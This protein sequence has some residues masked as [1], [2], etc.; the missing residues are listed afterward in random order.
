MGQG[1]QQLLAVVQHHLPLE[2]HPDGEGEMAGAGAGQVQH[3]FFFRRPGLQRQD[4]GSRT[5]HRLHKVAH[6]FPGGDIALRQQLAV[7]RLHG[8]LADFQMGSQCPLGG[9]LL[10]R[11][12]SSGKN[13][14]PDTAVQGLIEGHP[15]GFFQFVS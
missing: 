12:Q 6:L 3:R 2:L 5:L 14:T 1:L 13:I 15:R 7:S 11:R 8:D 9:Q 10:P 4:P